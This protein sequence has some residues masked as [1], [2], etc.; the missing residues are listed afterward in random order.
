MRCHRLSF[1]FNQAIY[2]ADASA[3]NITFQDKDLDELL[4]L[5][6]GQ[7]RQALTVQIL[8]TEWL[9]ASSWVCGRLQGITSA[10]EGGPQP[11]VD[12]W[13]LPMLGRDSEL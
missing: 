6:S 8:G 13:S 1:V 11:R 9:C 12:R 4:W 2:D 3:T 7:R 10:L 5:H